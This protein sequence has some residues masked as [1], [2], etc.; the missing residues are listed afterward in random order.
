MLSNSVKNIFH[1]TDNNGRLALVYISHSKSKIPK[2][3][4]FDFTND[5][6]Y[7]PNQMSITDATLL[8]KFNIL[9]I[10]LNDEMIAKTKWIDECNGEFVVLCNDDEIYHVTKDL[11]VPITT[12]ES[13]VKIIYWGEIFMLSVSGKLYYMEENAIKM[14]N[15]DH[16]IVDMVGSFHGVHIKIILLTETGKIYFFILV[17]HICSAPQYIKSEIIVKKIKTSF[18]YTIVLD[19]DHNLYLVDVYNK[20]LKLLSGLNIRT[21]KYHCDNS[22]VLIL[23]HDDVLYSYNIRSECYKKITKF[24]NDDQRIISLTGT[25]NY[26]LIVLNDGNVYTLDKDLTLCLV[27]YFVDNPFVVNNRS[28]LVKRALQEIIYL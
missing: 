5:R 20:S 4:T 23:D 15:F 10:G 22:R 18:Y 1:K 17:S 25:N 7:R 13:I 8:C 26:V 12:P 2:N 21:S 19:V 14:I 3:C 27:N 6:L 24:Y 28:L 9:D 16:R 11:V